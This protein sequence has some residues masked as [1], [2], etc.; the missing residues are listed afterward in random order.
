MSNS[1]PHPPI[2]RQPIGATFVVA[3]SILGLFAIVQ[4]CAIA[5]HF[6]PTVRQAVAT[7]ADH[8]QNPSYTAPTVPTPTLPPPTL[9]VQSSSNP[10]GLSM[11]DNQ[12]VK[13]LFDKT[14]HDFAV[15]D[16]ESAQ[17]CI[18][19]LEDLLPGNPSVLLR[20]A[21]V[22]EQT[23]QP[24]EAIAALQDVLKYKGLPQDTRDQA[25]K[26]ID[27]LNL[28]IYNTPPA[29]N[30][31]AVP[32]L[33]GGGDTGLRPGATLGI[34]SADLN[35]GRD[36]TKHLKVAVKARQGESVNV[37]DVKIVVYFYEAG[38]DGD[39]T[40]T[41]SKVISQ[42]LSPPIDWANDDPELLDMQYT[43]P[44]AESAPGKKYF[45]YVIGVYYNKELQA[46]R[47]EPAKLATD[48]PLPLFLKDQ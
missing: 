34:I 9:P 8:S 7:A 13:R 45:G 43:A 46:F 27:Q 17:K 18:E 1:T 30:P 16:F 36:G 44:N 5:V 35:D 47:S 24:A 23:D 39:V 26:K 12:K 2:P 31:S 28:T 29:K 21:R 38:D 4:L 10:T 11:A 15:G 40:L 42:W 20:K 3:I 25:L 22:L 37:Q 14:D 41:D 19:E 32:P 6:Y 33:T 48:F